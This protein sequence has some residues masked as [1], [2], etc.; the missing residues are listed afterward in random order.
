V[1]VEILGT[2]G[3]AV[4]LA[5]AGFHHG[6]DYLFGTQGAESAASD[7]LGV[8]F[9]GQWWLGAAFVAILAHVTSPRGILFNYDWMTL[10]VVVVIIAIG[11]VY[12]VVSRPARR[13]PVVGTAAAEVAT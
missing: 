3:I 7:T 6:I 13:I 5:I 2:F 8:D 10:L 11:A 12:S 4:L 9:G 1:Y